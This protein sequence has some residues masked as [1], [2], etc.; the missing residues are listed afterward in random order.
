MVSLK[1]EKRDK[2]ES[3]TKFVGIIVTTIFIVFVSDHLK[4]KTRKQNNL[5]R[6]ISKSSPTI[7]ALVEELNPCS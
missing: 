2:R 5:L 4:H 7:C 6:T 3:V 1:G